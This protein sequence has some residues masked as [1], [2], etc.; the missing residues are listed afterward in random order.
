MK[1][2]EREREFK[3]PVKELF[4]GKIQRGSFGGKISE[5]EKCPREEKKR[6][7]ERELKVPGKELFG[8]ENR[9]GEKEGAR[10]RDLAGN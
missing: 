4:G 9:G 3:V 7:R 10:G 8:G 5:G 2:R 6:D 1:E